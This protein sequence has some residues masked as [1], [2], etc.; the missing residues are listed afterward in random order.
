MPAV[1]EDNPLPPLVIRSKLTIPDLVEDSFSLIPRKIEESPKKFRK[2][3][4]ASRGSTAKR[5]FQELQL[6]KGSFSN[7][8]RQSAASPTLMESALAAAAA[9]AAAAA[10]T[11]GLSG[12]NVSPI[13]NTPVISRSLHEKTDSSL[14]FGENAK[15]AFISKFRELVSGQA[16]STVIKISK[17]E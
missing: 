12:K 2:E 17:G 1:L 6:L 5:S 4:S 10:D 16:S 9:A 8:M 11:A 3:R 13:K 15:I 7:N 14:Y